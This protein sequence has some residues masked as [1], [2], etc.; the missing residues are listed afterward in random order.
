MS[1]KNTTINNN[2][3]DAHQ[4]KLY[5]PMLKYVTIILILQSLYAYNLCDYIISTK[6]KK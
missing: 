2:F 1:T 5:L 4:V 3:F 6:Q